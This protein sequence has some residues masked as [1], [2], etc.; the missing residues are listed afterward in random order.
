[1]RMLGIKETRRSKLIKW[2]NWLIN[3]KKNRMPD[4]CYYIS[5]GSARLYYAI[6]IYKEGYRCFTVWLT[7]HSAAASL[8][9]LLLT[10]KSFS[11]ISHISRSTLLCK[12]CL[13]RIT[14][15]NTNIFCPQIVGSCF[16]II[17]DASGTFYENLLD[18]L[19]SFGTC[20]EV[21]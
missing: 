19:S 14:W 6:N 5:V 8:F 3:Q 4:I 17:V 7:I 18:A 16:N 15:L 9:L 21:K 1:M 20:L 10:A 13:E 11:R 12:W 2:R